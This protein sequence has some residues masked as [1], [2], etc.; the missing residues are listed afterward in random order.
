MWA[1]L[2]PCDDLKGPT[3]AVST[4]STMRATVYICAVPAGSQGALDMWLLRLKNGIFISM[5]CHLN[6]HACKKRGTDAGNGLGYTAGEGE[7][8]TN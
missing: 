2:L 5:Y 1:R 3:Q 8:G 6:C 4:L 7:G